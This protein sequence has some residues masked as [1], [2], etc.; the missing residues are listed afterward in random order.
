MENKSHALAAGAF[1]LLLLALLV[2][3]AVWLTRDTR[4]LRVYELASKEA[5]TGLQPQASVRFK[6][7]HVGKVTNIGFDPQTPGHVLIRIAIDDQA[8]IT[9]STFATLG[10]LGVTG[11]AFVQLDDSGESR[12]ALAPGPAQ[13]ARIPMR[14]SLL[15]QLSDQGAGI[16]L[17]LEESSR[18]FNLLL[19]PDNQKSLM[20]AIAD[21]GQAATGI[22]RLAADADQKLPQLTQDAQATLKTLQETSVRVGDSADEAR[23]SARAFR[24][25]TERMNEKGGTLDQLAEGANALVATGQTL[26]ATTLPRFNRAADAAARAARQTGQAA[27]ALGHNPQSLIFG[28]GLPAPGPGEPGFSAPLG[29][30]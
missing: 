21:M 8:P 25:V 26:N 30:P 12:V 20:Q 6:G 15:S 7:V 19:K 23:D 11:L 4:E 13:P 5:V 27:D 10:F 18:R 24:Q 29:K 1:V 28:N 22:Q 17:Q 16:L 14:P 9:R 2:A 3:L